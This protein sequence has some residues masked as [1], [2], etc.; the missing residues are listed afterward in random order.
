MLLG[1]N[2]SKNHRIKFG[3]VKKTAYLCG[4]KS[5]GLLMAI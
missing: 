5:Y 4:V 1:E 2:F 3:S